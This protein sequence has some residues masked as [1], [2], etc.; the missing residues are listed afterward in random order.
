MTGLV[1]HSS[2]LLAE[3]VRLAYG[4]TRGS[5]L[6]V[7]LVAL[8]A[9]ATALAL[10]GVVAP[11]RLVPWLV[12]ML[13]I[14]ASGVALRRAYRRGEPHADAAMPVWMR[15]KVAQAGALGLGW[16]LGLVLLHDRG[17]AYTLLYPVVGLVAVAAGQAALHTALITGLY[18]FLA[19]SLLPSV[20][21][22]L[23]LPGWTTSYV[24]LGLVM[25]GGF[26]VVSSQ[27]IGRVLGDALRMRLA[28]AELLEQERH[29]VAK[30][31]H[32]AALTELAAAEKTRFW[33]AASHDLKQPL[34]ALGLYSALLRKD[35]A[36]VERR[37]L[38]DHI[39][40]CVGSLTGL[41]D[42]ILGVTHAETAH[43]NAKPG[44]FPLQRV[45]EQVLIQ[46]RPG[47]RAKGLTVR[48]V[49][50][51]LWVHADPAVIERILG[52]LL[53]NAVR[54]TEDGRILVGVR[55]RPGGCSLIVADTGVGLASHDQSRIFDDFFQV[56]NPERQRDKGYGL[57]L[58]TVHRL[59]AAL[60]YEIEVQSTPGRGSL[61]AVTLPLDSPAHA[62]E[63]QEPVHTLEADLNVL[64]VED[65][66]LVR[67]AMN[68][69]LKD[70]GVRVSMC[71]CGDE[72]LAI[73]SQEFDKR[74]HVLLDHQL[75][76][77]E[78]GLQ[79]ADRIRALIGDGPVISLVTGE[80][81]EAVDRGAAERGI[82]VLRKPLK[83]IRLRALLRSHHLG[84]EVL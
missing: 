39:T 29:L 30:A 2:R 9:C 33:S 54:Y 64:F 81:D 80:V 1:D 37:E 21:Y 73:L 46:V 63:V 8:A 83:P 70:W 18:S 51:S 40:S 49:P 57:G 3:Q 10:K 71:A 4:S 75:A 31:E 32:S 11:Y 79:V 14:Q 7:G 6:L 19:C 15:L 59:C 60:G 61:F 65:D 72:A 53:S 84:E 26:L 38:I 43:L 27:L 45:V 23:W 20:A 35:P 34:H 66:P 25:L 22:L 47:A 55:R 12:L 17:N 56:D 82:S 28:A 41:F 24:A 16:G 58:S 77:N 68:R 76:D 62:E 52:N 67:D 44:A 48:N 78:T 74:W 13:L 42:A 36:D 5:R 50:T 69:L